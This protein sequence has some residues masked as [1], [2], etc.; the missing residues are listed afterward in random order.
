MME[1]LLSKENGIIRRRATT[2]HNRHTALLEYLFRNSLKANTKST[3]IPAD[4]LKFRSF[5]NIE[6][7]G[8]LLNI[9]GII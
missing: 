8:N 1:K 5:M 3:S 9:F 6:V 2:I 4:M 7:I